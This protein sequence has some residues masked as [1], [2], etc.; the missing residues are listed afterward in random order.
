MVE[1]VLV[2]PKPNQKIDHCFVSVEWRLIFP[3]SHMCAI[4]SSMSNHCIMKLT[5][6]LGLPS[7]KGFRFEDY[8]L[9]QR[10]LLEIVTEAWGRPI[11][12]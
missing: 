10:G 4:T 8:W 3:Q 12:A 7:Y 5:G 2:R 1:Q 9:K 6:Q 11:Q